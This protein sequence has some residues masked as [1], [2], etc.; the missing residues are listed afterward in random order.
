[1]ATIVHTTINLPQDLFVQAKMYSAGNRLTL[2]DLVKGAVEKV[3]SGEISLVKEMPKLGRFLVGR[4][5]VKKIPYQRRSDV[6]ADHIK[7]KLVGGY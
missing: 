2:S 5:L 3:M 6:Y 7:R 4:K 1:M